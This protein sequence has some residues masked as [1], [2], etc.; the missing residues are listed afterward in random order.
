VADCHPAEC[1]PCDA[2]SALSHISILQRNLHH[3]FYGVA[4]RQLLAE[5]IQMFLLMLP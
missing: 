3:E 1:E 2:I 5:A 4:L